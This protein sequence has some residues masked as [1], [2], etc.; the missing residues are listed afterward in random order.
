[1]QVVIYSGHE[2]VVVVVVVV[3]VAAVVVVVVVELVVVVLVL[4]LEELKYEKQWRTSL[5]M[6]AWKMIVECC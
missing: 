4:Y 5:P 6:F 1:M 2:T 3:V